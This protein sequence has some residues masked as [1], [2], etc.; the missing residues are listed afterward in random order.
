MSYSVGVQN[1]LDRRISGYG[2]GEHGVYTL[3]V[4]KFTFEKAPQ[5]ALC[6]FFFWSFSVGDVVT[7]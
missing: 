5:R 4:S 7:R 1:F 6:F 2:A 3:R